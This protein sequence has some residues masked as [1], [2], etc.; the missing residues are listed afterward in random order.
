MEVPLREHSL[1]LSRRGRNGQ[2][3]TCFSPPAHLCQQGFHSFNCLSHGHQ[4]IIFIIVINDTTLLLF[5]SHLSAPY[6]CPQGGWQHKRGIKET[7]KCH[8]TSVTTILRQG[9][10]ST[11]PVSRQ[12]CWGP[13][14][15][16]NSGRATLA[17]SWAG[18]G[19]M[20]T[21]P[22]A[23]EQFCQAKVQ[24]KPPCFGGPASQTES[25][26]GPPDSTPPCLRVFPS[27]AWRCCQSRSSTICHLTPW[28]LPRPAL[29]AWKP[30]LGNVSLPQHSPASL[31]LARMLF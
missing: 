18:V 23:G 29:T 2:T 28:S 27:P 14:K 20:Q 6:W 15:G 8:R 5:A 3:R 19:M 1:Q 25:P 26:L 16:S 7:S 21:P 4:I 12:G 22:P 24:T 9:P 31:R 13:A 17:R 10:I 11:A 30:Q